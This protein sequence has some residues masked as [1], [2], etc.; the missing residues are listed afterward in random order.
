MKNMLVFKVF[1]YVQINLLNVKEQKVIGYYGKIR[2]EN[3][4]VPEI[5][6]VFR[7]R[8][9]SDQPTLRHADG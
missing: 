9:G 5:C 1:C 2:N 7:L 3:I 8:P 6:F 4:I